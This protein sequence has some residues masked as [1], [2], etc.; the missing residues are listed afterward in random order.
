MARQNEPLSEMERRVFGE[1]AT[2]DADGNIQETGIGSRMNPTAA[3]VDTSVFESAP[4]P[5][6]VAPVPPS[7]AGVPA[8]VPPGPAPGL[9]AP[10]TETMQ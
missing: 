7:P 2:R 10:S 5:A 3:Q 4:P 9:W 6:A 1:N 8:A